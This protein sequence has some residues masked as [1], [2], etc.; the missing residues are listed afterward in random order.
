MYSKRLHFLA[1]LLLSLWVAAMTTS[2]LAA[3]SHN[4]TPTSQTLVNAGRLPQQLVVGGVPREMMPIEG[5]VNGEPTGFSGDLLKQLLAGSGIQLTAR[6]YPNRKA[7]LKAACDG[8]VDLIMS[9]VPRNEFAHCLIYSAPYL[10]RSI[11]LV[12]REGDARALDDVYLD[13][14]RVVLERGSPWASE[15][16]EMHPNGK[17]VEADTITDA[18]D[19]LASGKVDLYVGITLT[20]SRLLDRSSYTGLR[21]VRLIT[22]HSEGFHYGAPIGRR[23]VISELDRRLATLSPD[24][25]ENLRGRW[26]YPDGGAANN[27]SGAVSE[28]VAKAIEKKGVLR[29]TVASFLP[30]YSVEGDGKK[31][32]GI[33]VDYLAH[34]G[35]DLNLPVEYVPTANLSEAFRLAEAGEIDLVAG[36]PGHY[37]APGQMLPLGVYESPPMVIV[38]PATAPYIPDLTALTG[39][40]LAI[41]GNDPMADTIR[42]HTPDTLH[43]G[44]ETLRDALTAVRSGDAVATIGNLTTMDALLRQDYAGE[45]RIAGHAGFSEDFAVLAGPHMSEFVP[46][47]R[48]MLRTIPDTERTRIRDRWL[49]ASYQFYTPWDLILRRALPFLLIGAAACLIVGFSF[50]RLRKEIRLRTATERQLTHQLSFKEALLN[51]LPYPVIAKDGAQRYVEVN[52][53]FEDVFGI[54]RNDI[55]GKTA[56]S[57]EGAQASVLKTMD[58]RSFDSATEAPLELTD[59]SG[60]KRTVVHIQQEY[61]DAGGG[62]NGVIGTLF[63]ITDIH[64]ARE[65]A[66]LLERRLQDVTNSL[67]AIVFQMRHVF[68]SGQPVEIT[69]AAG[70]SDASMG[71]TPKEIL[72]T[73]ELL[74]KYLH[75]DDVERVRSAFRASQRTQEPVEQE[76]RL[77]GRYGMRWV[78][79]RAICR[80]DGDETVWSGVIADVTEQHYQ[81]DALGKAR[82]VA[83]AALRAKEG[84]LAMMSHEIRTPLNGVLGLIEVLQTTSLSSAQHKMLSLVEESGHALAQILNDVLDYAKIEAGRL[85]IIP[86]PTDLR[87]LAD[88]VVGL[89]APQAYSKG[90]N[91]Y[92]TIDDDVPAT[93]HADAIR[94]RQIFFN[95]LGNAIK[96]TDRGSIS[97]GIRAKA[98]EEGDITLAISVTDTGIGIAPQDASRLF[99]PFVQ[100]EHQTTRR[101]GGTGLG[102]S[103][104]KRL[105][106]LMEGELTLQST[107]GEGTTVTLVVRCPVVD[108]RYDFPRF[109]GHRLHIQVEDAR[110]DASLRAYAAAAGLAVVNAIRDAG[111]L[112]M[113]SDMAEAPGSPRCRRIRVTSETEQLGFSVSDGEIRLS[114]NPLRWSAFLACIQEALALDDVASGEDA[115]DLPTQA[116]SG[117][118]LA[119]AHDGAPRQH[120]LVAEDHGISRELVRQQLALLGY[121][122]TLCENGQEAM[123]AL[124]HRRFDI[125]VTDCHM[126]VMDG[127]ELTRWIRAS[128]DPDLR[129][130]PVIGVTATTLADEHQRCFE[131]GMDAYV[132]KPT[133]LASIQRALTRYRDAE[134]AGDDA[135]AA[136]PS[137]T[138]DAAPIGFD[139]TLIRREDL[140]GKSGAL[141][142]SDE[143]FR[144]CESAIEEDRRSL[145][146][147]LEDVSVDDLRKWCHRAGG[148]LAV[149]EQPE[150]NGLIGRFSDVVKAADVAKIQVV[151]ETVTDMLDHILDLLR[152]ASTREG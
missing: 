10:V 38:I 120:V 111:D 8:E 82:D 132:L 34:L 2:A 36:L 109:A 24:T 86:A 60:R 35:K 84:F 6:T 89:L 144:V 48:R 93:V 25:I 137:A 108:A 78:T 125:V 81:A 67:P 47:M 112:C 74:S 59:V 105:T 142:W 11:V 106:E 73:P 76:C 118:P 107:L 9:A 123:Q 131:V 149:F 71:L 150:I 116:P 68:A 121:D 69:Y 22:P 146:K 16:I 122:C 79:I 100:S 77:L 97:L 63:D 42:S 66:Q 103:I 37:P 145:L 27:A 26:F 43:V 23:A 18:L 133:T 19:M 20:I 52:A 88:S 12:A 141:Q 90:L 91:V 128:P 15:W 32:S 54:R 148:G 134:H 31:V 64:E 28:E 114:D 44:V 55:I 61:R 85:S 92:I 46:V 53:A 21:A 49:T 29:Y 143:M 96:F 138:E 50:V 4:G 58:E 129:R 40:S 41:A 151:G 62:A 124:Q 95:L 110:T 147:C 3:T 139:R 152:E 113:R 140:F 102:L 56:Q 51:C 7:L 117:L 94:I 5:V 1:S 72:A 119:S 14:A 130:L 80:R 99:A 87:E 39:K 98:A 115:A 17:V 135:E 57:L 126:P 75:P 136:D 30:P 101:F 65:Q 127:F 45:L 33:T 70:N 13:T 83:E 104:C